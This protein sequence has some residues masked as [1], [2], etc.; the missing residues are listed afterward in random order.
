VTRPKR[1]PD[2]LERRLD[3][4]EVA[5]GFEFRD[6]ALLQRALTH[7]SWAAE[8]AGAGEYERLEILGDSIVGFVVVDHVY[9]AFPDADEGRIARL[10]SEVVSGES[11]AEAADRAGIAELVL[12]GEGLEP[13]TRRH[14]SILA[15]V[16]EALVA[17]VYLDQG[18]RSARK[19]VTRLLIPFALPLALSGA[20]RDPKGVLQEHLMAIKAPA[21]VYTVVDESGPP[22]D[23]RFAIE[24]SIGGEVAG[25]GCGPSKKVAEKAAAAE[26]LA[27]FGID[28]AEA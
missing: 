7:P 11:L 26:A 19:V 27:T 20:T 13:G 23:R 5:L 1:H 18:L 9:R 4:A 17:A 6:R 21:P 8:H 10:K 14:A 28:P 22:H 15:D 16:F 25:R 2:D 24:V 12:V 3:A